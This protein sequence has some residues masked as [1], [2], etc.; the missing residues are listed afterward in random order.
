MREN[1]VQVHPLSHSFYFVV[2]FLRDA[3]NYVFN[4]FHMLNNIFVLTLYLFNLC[5]K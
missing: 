2:K 4:M 5:V 3:C 1:A